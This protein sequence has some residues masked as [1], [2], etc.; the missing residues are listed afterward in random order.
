MPVFLMYGLVASSFTPKSIVTWKQIVFALNI[1]T[2]GNP[3]P[4]NIEKKICKE[5]KQNKTKQ[6][7]SCFVVRFNIW[8]LLI[9]THPDERSYY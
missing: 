3:D 8:F 6:E 9:P 5:T 7:F 4:T 1:S 2:T